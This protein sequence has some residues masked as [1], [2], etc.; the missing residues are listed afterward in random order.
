MGKM[1]HGKQVDDFVLLYLF[2]EINVI[3]I[4]AVFS[5]AYYISTVNYFIL[6]KKTSI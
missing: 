1:I 3:A 5:K 2:I 6:L 4:S